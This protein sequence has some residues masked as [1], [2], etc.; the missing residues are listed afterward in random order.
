MG[1]I[2]SFAGAIVIAA[3]SMMAGLLADLLSPQLA[4]IALVI[5]SCPAIFIYHFLYKKHSN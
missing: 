2:I 5:T 1:S 3:A 4:I